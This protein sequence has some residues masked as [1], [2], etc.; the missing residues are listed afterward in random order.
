MITVYVSI[1]NSDDKLT[2]AEWSSYALDVDRAVNKAMGYVGSTVH[3]RWYSLPSE[4]WQNACWC[5]AWDDELAHIVE[6]LKRSLATIARSYRQD[7]IAWATA[8]TEF[9]GAPAAVVHASPGCA[10]GVNGAGESFVDPICR[11]KP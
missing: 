7:S 11:A 5:L 10:C 2:Q 9:I 3:G 6:A 8:T 1:G 4:P